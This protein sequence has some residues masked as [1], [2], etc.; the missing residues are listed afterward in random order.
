MARFSH[1]EFEDL[2]PQTELAAPQ[3]PYQT[4]LQ[5]NTAQ[6]VVT[7]D[8][9]YIKLADEQYLLGLFDEALKLYSRAL[10]HNAN[11]VDGWIGQT[12]MLLEL[13]EL[14]EAKLWSDKSLQIFHN[15]PDLLSL[16]GVAHCRLGDRQKAL[17]FSDGAFSQPGAGSFY[18]W[19][20]RG[21]IL[22]AVKGKQ[23]SFAL[24]KALSMPGFPQWFRHLLVARAFY[25]HR[26]YSQATQQV[27]DSLELRTD[28][29][30]AWHT[31]GNCQQALRQFK[32]AETS[33]KEA[34]LLWPTY[35]ASSEA[36][37]SLSGLGYFKRFFSFG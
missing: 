21:E 27:R 24:D 20:A 37:K 36:L 35:T 8:F 3:S 13:G 1:L 10:S 5:H 25:F 19:L 31:L 2:P 17:G 15:N 30:F 16:Q 34:L 33:Y 29:P 22:L 28:S 14:K 26:R 18:T 12:R 4:H 23:A 11:N 7:D 9:H 6:R 32:K